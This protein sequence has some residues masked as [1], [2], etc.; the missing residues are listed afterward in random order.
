MGLSGLLCKVSKV[1]VQF[2]QEH[3]YRYYSWV[4]QDYY[5]KSQKSWFSL[6]KNMFI[7]I[8]SGFIRVII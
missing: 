8:I 1:L 2:L 6:C 3:V 5:V 7:G 4:Y